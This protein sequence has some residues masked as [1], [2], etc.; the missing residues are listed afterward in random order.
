M[1]DMKCKVL[2]IEH[3]FAVRYLLQNQLK[4]HGY[5]AFIAKSAQAGL[6]F[7]RNEQIDLVALNLNIPG[8]DGFGLFKQMKDEPSMASI[9]VVFIAEQAEPSDRTIAFEL[10]AED[11][12]VKPFLAD[13]FLARITAVLKKQSV[14]KVSYPSK[15]RI[16]T[17]FSPKGGVGTTTLAI[18]LAKAISIQNEQET[19]LLDLNLPLGGIAQKLN[20]YSDDHIVDFLKLT[21]EQFDRS[22]GAR[23]IQKLQT[24]F[25]VV[26]APGQFQSSRQA[27]DANRLIYLFDYLN[28]Q[29]ITVIVDAG[30]Q[31]NSLTLAALRRSDTVFAVT[32]GRIDANQ[33][34]NSFLEQSN[35]LRIDKKRILPVVNE[36]YGPVNDQVELAQLPVAHIPSVG[37]QAQTR[38]WLQSQG[39]RKLISFAC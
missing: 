39:I 34:V 33:M 4:E 25:F 15:S 29:N 10:G 23:F 18:Q 16:L 37:H 11:F 31:I 6:D 17:F 20:L 26:P 9:P 21:K 38:L 14:K 8:S 13:E 24:N 5:H 19:I 1:N 36:I 28:Q 7:L 27:P 3:E 32:T 22:D 35:E 30:S 2:L 12:I